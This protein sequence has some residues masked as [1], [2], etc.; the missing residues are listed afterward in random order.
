[1]DCPR[2]SG[3]I[4]RALEETPAD[5]Q[6]DLVQAWL[7]ERR[8]ARS[9]WQFVRGQGGVQIGGVAFIGDPEHVGA[10]LAD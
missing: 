9:F 6:L 4:A 2:H 5:E 3:W 8:A 1:M 10:L 7:D